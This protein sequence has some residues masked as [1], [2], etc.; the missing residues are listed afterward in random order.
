MMDKSESSLLKRDRQE[1]QL[2]ELT[3]LAKENNKM[4]RGERN[5]RKIKMILVL[6]VLFGLAGYGYYFFEKHKIKIIEFQQRAEE[7]QSHVQEAAQLIERIGETAD[8]VRAMF[9]EG[10]SNTNETGI[11]VTE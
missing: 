10:G 2:R 8:S 7:L 11:P 5:A 3:K 9:E 1:K 6:M 4:L